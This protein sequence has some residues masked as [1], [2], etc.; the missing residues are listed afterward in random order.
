MEN[1]KPDRI[2]M[3]TSCDANAQS[4][5][6]Q[7]KFVDHAMSLLYVL[8]LI[9]NIMVVLTIVW[10][11][12]A[13]S[14]TP[15]Q[16]FNQPNDGAKVI[17]LDMHPIKTTTLCQPKEI[18][19]FSCSTVSN[20]IVSLCASPDIS[21]KAGYMQLRVGKNINTLEIEYPKRH[22][23]P[24]LSFKQSVQRAQSGTASAISFKINAN[25]YTLFL[26]KT[27][28]E[29]EIAGVVLDNGKKLVSFDQCLNETVATT[30]DTGGIINGFEFTE[31]DIP[32]AKDDISFAQL[33]DVSAG[34]QKGIDAISIG[35]EF[36]PE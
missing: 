28:W 34:G 19:A 23:H 30:F 1:M 7:V 22:S 14:A 9:R 35:S 24:S 16:N 2:K 29:P 6:F 36:H 20:N 10:P 26:T 8:T 17:G 13:Q 18:I 33:E 5:S 25:R 32:D 4:S 12:A 31:L 21:K 3:Q 27:Q 15:A 11:V